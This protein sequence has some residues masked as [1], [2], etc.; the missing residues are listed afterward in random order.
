MSN[1]LSSPQ[2]QVLDTNG[3]PV[4]GAKA[5]FYLAG[6]TTATDI[7][8]E[9]SLTTPHANPVIADSTGTFASIYIDTTIALKCVIKD[10][11]DVTIRT[12]DYVSTV[13]NAREKLTASKS[14]YVSTTGSDSNNGSSGNPFLTIQN[15][16]EIASNFDVGL[17]NITINVEDG[18]YTENLIFKSFVGYG[19]IIINGD[20]VTPSN[21]VIAGGSGIG[22]KGLFATGSYDIRGLT[23]TGT[24]SNIQ[25]FG[26]RLYFRNIDFK[27][28]GSQIYLLD[29]SV[30]IAEGDYEVSAS[31]AR[32]IWAAAGGFVQIVNRTITITGTPAWSAGFMVAGGLSNMLVYGN[33]YSGSATGVR[34]VVVGNS[35][36]QTA[37]GGASYFPGD[38]A[39]STSSGGQYL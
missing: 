20:T 9:K 29:G 21:V 33:T 23:L 22:V 28:S 2:F 26:T 1:F 18:T 39:G 10:A 32:H 3:D 12:I 6:T 14:Y 24:A 38:S 7:Y 8:Q 31:C 34:Y 11:D 16:I 25:L 13:G 35:V 5:Y 4:V 17:Y 36:V 27:S 37:G 15:A 30:L 19:K